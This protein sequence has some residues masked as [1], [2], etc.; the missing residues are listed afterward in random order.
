VSQLTCE[1]CGR[2]Y[3]PAALG[4]EPQL[5]GPCPSPRCGGSLRLEHESLDRS[6]PDRVVAVR[7]AIA[8][9]GRLPIS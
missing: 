9:P 7:S 3:E 4:R 1:D 8:G 5:T 6:G 2:S